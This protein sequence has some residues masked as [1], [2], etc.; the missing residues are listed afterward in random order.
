MPVPSIMMGLG[1]YLDDEKESHDH[2]CR[3][4]GE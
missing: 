4:R 1:S 2:Y 3:V